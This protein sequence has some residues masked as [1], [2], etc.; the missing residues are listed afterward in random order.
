MHRFFCYLGAATRSVF[1]FHKAEGSRNGVIL[2]DE[3]GLGKSIQVILFLHFMIMNTHK[4]KNALLVMPAGLLS[5]WKGKLENWTPDITV[6]IYQNSDKELLSKLR[7]LQKT[8]GILLVS[9]KMFIYHHETLTTYKG[10]PFIWDCL[11]FDEAHRLKN[12]ATKNHKVAA[13]ISAGFHILVTGT[14]IQNNLKEYWSLRIPVYFSVF[15]WYCISVW[16]GIFLKTLLLWTDIF[17]NG[18]KNR[19]FKNTRVLPKYPEL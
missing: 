19:V 14:P 4:W 15:E 7:R 6:L 5:D 16:T 8:G 3:M 18:D 17:K 1:L 12:P 13:S 2:A 10:M 9:Y 11:V